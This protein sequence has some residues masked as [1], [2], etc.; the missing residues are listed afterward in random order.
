VTDY[1]VSCGDAERTEDAGEYVEFEAVRD[2]L[3]V[4]VT[5]FVCEECL[6]E[7]RV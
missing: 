2:E 4:Y 3:D 6:G 1:C 5:R 7:V